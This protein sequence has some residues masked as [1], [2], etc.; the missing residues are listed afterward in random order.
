MENLE[1]LSDGLSEYE[2]CA[3]LVISNPFSQERNLILSSD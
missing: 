1:Y 2:P 3:I